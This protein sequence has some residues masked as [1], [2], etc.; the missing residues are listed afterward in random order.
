[1]SWTEEEEE[2]DINELILFVFVSFKLKTKSTYVHQGDVENAKVE[3][4]GQR[5]S[6]EEVLVDPGVHHEQTL[7]LRKTVESVE[8]FNGDQN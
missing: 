2:K 8:H 3:D 7:V 5:D 4:H 6:A 1:M